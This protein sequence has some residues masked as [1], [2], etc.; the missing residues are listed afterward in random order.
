M[1]KNA[2]EKQEKGGKEGEEDRIKIICAYIFD[3]YFITLQWSWQ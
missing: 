3:D 1:R 2:L